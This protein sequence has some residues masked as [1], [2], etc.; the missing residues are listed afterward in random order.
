MNIPTQ[1]ELVKAFK[2]WEAVKFIDGPEKA[3]YMKCMDLVATN[4]I[5]KYVGLT[6]SSDDEGC[7][8]CGS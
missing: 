1:E 4:D 2:A 3:Y 8:T 5:N 7:L 6:C